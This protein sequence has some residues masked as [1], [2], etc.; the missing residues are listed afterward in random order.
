M[1]ATPSIL[2]RPHLVLSKIVY[3]LWETKWKHQTENGQWKGGCKP[4]D[5][6]KVH[7]EPLHEV[8]GGR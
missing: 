8:G 4:R 7:V 6:E 2:L 3:I 1:P 5:S